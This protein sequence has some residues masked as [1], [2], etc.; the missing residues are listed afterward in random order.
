MAARRRGREVRVARSVRI[1]PSVLER[2]NDVYGSLTK[3]IN[4]K[5]ESDQLLGDKKND[6][7]GQDNRDS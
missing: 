6:C 5:I 3:F 4:K 7:S 2:I 1:E